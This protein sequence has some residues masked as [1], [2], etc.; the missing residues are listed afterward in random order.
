MRSQVT[1]RSSWHKW[2]H[3]RHSAFGLRT[4]L[5][6]SLLRF[7]LIRWQRG[8]SCDFFLGS[9]TAE[10]FRGPML[11]RC[12]PAWL[13]ATR[14]I[15]LIGS[16]YPANGEIFATIHRRRDHC[17][18]AQFRIR[19]KSSWNKISVKMHPQQSA[20]LDLV[21]RLANAM[22][23]YPRKVSLN[24]NIKA[25]RR[26]VFTKKMPHSEQWVT[27]LGSPITTAQQP[28]NDQSS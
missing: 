24:S 15:H 21:T 17:E 20:C 16:T 23:F 27:E 19:M 28:T 11:S 4:I 9:P 12:S 6:G 7:C 14:F 10:N 18:N 5:M 26:H 3:W 13:R 2:K 1:G 8:H 25:L 22:I